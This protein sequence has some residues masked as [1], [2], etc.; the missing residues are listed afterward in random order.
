MLLC[1]EKAGKSHS[2]PGY[3]DIGGPLVWKYQNRYYVIG[4]FARVQDAADLSKGP[5]GFINIA[6]HAGW[7]WS[8]VKDSGF[9]PDTPPTP[10]KPKTLD[11]DLRP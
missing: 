5:A 9:N 6:A 4:M 3:G 2:H 10:P 1:T 8:V 7:I 11:Q